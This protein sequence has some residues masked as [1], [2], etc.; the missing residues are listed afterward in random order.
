VSLE[1]LD[2]FEEYKCKVKVPHHEDIWGV[3]RREVDI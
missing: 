1:K 3:G 2:Y